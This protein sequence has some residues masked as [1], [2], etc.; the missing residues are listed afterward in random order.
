VETTVAEGKAT[1]VAGVGAIV[2][3]EAI[4]RVG[5]QPVGGTSIASCP[6]T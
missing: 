4:T 2:G 1:A 5:V 6:H 3:A